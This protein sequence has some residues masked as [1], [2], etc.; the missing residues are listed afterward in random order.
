[1]RRSVSLLSIILLLTFWPANVAAQA[2]TFT[3]TDE[4]YTLELPSPAWVAVRAA[5]QAYRHTRFVYHG[6][7]DWRLRVR[8]ELIDRGIT[9]ATLADDEEQSL[10][11]LPAY[12]RTQLEPFAGRLNGTKLT[13]EY[14]KGGRLMAGRAYFLQADKHTVYI[15][16]FT[17]VRDLQESLRAQTDFIARSFRSR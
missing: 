2:R 6:S 8:R 12:V 5:G 14:S 7:S 9:T 11:F 16:R 10:R 17:G 1:M 4:G 3:D 15:L 13:Y